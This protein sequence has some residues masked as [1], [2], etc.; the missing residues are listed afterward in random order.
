MIKHNK[1]I[2]KKLKKTGGYY[3]QREGPQLV[4]IGWPFYNQEWSILALI[5]LGMIFWF[6]LGLISN[7]DNN[8]SYSDQDGYSSI[9]GSID[10]VAQVNSG[11]Q[12]Y[13]KKPLERSI[14]APS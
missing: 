1:S 12:T 7:S 4:R 11:T 2:R 6:V 5:F 8:G 13:E 10:A 14:S 9:N 3:R